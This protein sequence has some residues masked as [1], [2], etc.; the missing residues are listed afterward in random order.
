LARI[1]K[2]KDLYEAKYITG[3]SPY[4]H[5]LRIWRTYNLLDKI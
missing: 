2:A 5:K 1:A 3:V 4:S